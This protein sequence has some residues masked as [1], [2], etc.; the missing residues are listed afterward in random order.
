MRRSGR[1]QR[2]KPSAAANDIGL[3]TRALAREQ[4]RAVRKMAGL[5]PKEVSGGEVN[6]DDV[7]IRLDLYCIF[8][9]YFHDKDNKGVGKDKGSRAGSPP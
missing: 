5:P 9:R 6:S 1:P 4:N 2:R 8:D 7:Q 3:N